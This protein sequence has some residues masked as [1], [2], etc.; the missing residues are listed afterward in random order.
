MK[1]KNLV[2]ICKI[3]SKSG[4][5]EAMLEFV[6][7]R[8]REYG[9][10]VS[11]D[12]KGNL[13]AKKGDAE[14]YP[15]MVSHVDTVHDIVPDDEYTVLHKNGAIFAY[16]YK[17]FT[18]TGVGGDDKVGIF[19]TLELL[20]KFDDIKVAF[21]VEEETGCN[22]SRAADKSFFDDVE[23]VLQCDR[24]GI[25]DFVNKISGIELYSDEFSEAIK[26]ILKRYNRTETTGGLT[27]VKQLA[28][29]GV[30]VCVANMSCGYYRPHRDNEYIVVEDVRNTYKLCVDI[31][32]EVSGKVW[33]CEH[34]SSYSYGNINYYKKGKVK[35]FR[36]RGG[37]FK[38]ISRPNDIGYT[39]RL[40][41]GDTPSIV[42]TSSMVD[43]DLPNENNVN[44]RFF[45][46]KEGGKLVFK[47]VGENKKEVVDEKK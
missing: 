26:P 25:E 45:I 43:H 31:I 11:Y 7:Q 35:N 5:E 39:N 33:E 20:R 19:I 1:T 34:K 10:V 21:F 6:E 14:T 29:K 24:K 40:W 42:T 41:V 18:S 8:C 15:C 2:E 30:N 32:N 9:A 4:K 17:K 22:G 36:K 23:F 13:Y 3:Q 44:T 38:N 47:K 28:T 46:T 16:N 27:D 37:S 12:K